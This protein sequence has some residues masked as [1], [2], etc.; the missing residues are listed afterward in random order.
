M[1][2]GFQDSV[3]ARIIWMPGW[4]SQWAPKG[5]WDDE[6]GGDN[7]SYLNFSAVPERLSGLLDL[8]LTPGLF[9]TRARNVDV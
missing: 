5:G 7:F 2:Q 4:Y 1:A 8:T 6:L 3:A 9:L